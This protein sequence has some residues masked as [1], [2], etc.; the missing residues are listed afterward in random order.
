MIL[1]RGTRYEMERYVSV[2]NTRGARS[3]NR[4]VRSEIDTVSKQA[5]DIPAVT[6]L[7]SRSGYMWIGLENRVR[8]W[9]RNIFVDEY[10]YGI[11]RASSNKLS[12]R[13]SRKTGGSLSRIGIRRL[14]RR[15]TLFVYGSFVLSVS[16]TCSQK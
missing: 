13:P 16:S 2:G 8:A 15:I 6:A 11:A 10:K 5:Y 1:I 7:A 9:L 3:I 4:R 14:L 12:R